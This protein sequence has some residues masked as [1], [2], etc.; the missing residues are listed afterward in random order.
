METWGVADI[1]TRKFMENIELSFAASCLCT[2]VGCSFF[3]GEIKNNR[4]NA[5]TH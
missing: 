4:L 2:L 5:H 1:T 3:F